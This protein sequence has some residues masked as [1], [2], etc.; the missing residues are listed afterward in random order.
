MILDLHRQGLSASVFARQFGVGRK[1]VWAKGLEPS[2]NE[3]RAQGRVSSITSKPICA[4]D[5]RPIP[6]SPPCG[7]G[8]GSRNADSLGYSVV[9][10]RV[11]GLRPSQL[12]SFEVRFEPPTAEQAQVDFARAKFEVEFVDELGVERTSGCPRRWCPATHS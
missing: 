2:V 12:A 6:H 9:H 8:V 3:K 10:D 1:T 7:C 11:R 5:W 4:N